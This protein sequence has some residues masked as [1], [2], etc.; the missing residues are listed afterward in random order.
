MKEI[1]LLETQAAYYSPGGRGISFPLDPQ[2]KIHRVAGQSPVGA[3]FLSRG[4]AQPG[5]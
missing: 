1:V 4:P 2:R 5:K 3:T